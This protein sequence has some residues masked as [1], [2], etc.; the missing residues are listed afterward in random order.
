MGLTV[1]A[2]G[3]RATGRN[4]ETGAGVGRRSRTSVSTGRRSGVRPDEEC[5]PG[6]GPLLRHG[7]SRADGRSPG[8]SVG[9]GR[10]K[11]GSWVRQSFGRPSR[12]PVSGGERPGSRVRCRSNRKR[13]RPD[14]Q[15][16]DPR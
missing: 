1:S 14:G 10:R 4:D 11:R 6:L 7:T 8:G 3:G 13:V 15:T 9:G 2:R 16:V 12:G 5:F